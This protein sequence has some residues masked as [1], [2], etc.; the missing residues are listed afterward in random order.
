MSGIF[1][2]S[3]DDD[4]DERINHLNLKII[5]LNYIELIYI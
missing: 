4:D 2:E 5:T 3:V 1:I